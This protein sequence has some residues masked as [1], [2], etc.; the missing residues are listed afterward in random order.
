MMK[1][2]E[3]LKAAVDAL[4]PLPPELPAQKPEEET[5]TPEEKAK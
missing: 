4:K 1:L 2:L 3:G 5:D